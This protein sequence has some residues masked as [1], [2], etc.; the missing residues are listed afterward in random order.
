MKSTRNSMYGSRIWPL[1]GWW[2]VVESVSSKHEVAFMGRCYLVL[3]SSEI[4]INACLTNAAD[5][6]YKLDVSLG[7]CIYLWTHLG[8]PDIGWTLTSKF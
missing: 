2:L 6:Y 1:W 3:V 7:T 4:N 8:C 5:Q